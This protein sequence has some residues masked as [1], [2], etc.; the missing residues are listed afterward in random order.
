MMEVVMAS[1]VGSLVNI[2]NALIEQFYSIIDKRRSSK[3]AVTRKNFLKCSDY[4]FIDMNLN[5]S[6]R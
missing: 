5:V 3:S 2:Q 6:S 1:A 4:N